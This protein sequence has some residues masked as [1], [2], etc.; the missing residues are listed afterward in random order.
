MRVLSGI[1]LIIGFM[2]LG[3]SEEFFSDDPIYGVA[4]LVIS[5]LFIFI[6]YLF[7]KKSLNNEHE[8]YIKENPNVGF[9]RIN[10]FVTSNAKKIGVKM[11]EG[12]KVYEIVHKSSYF[13]KEGNYTIEITNGNKESINNIVHFTVES[14]NVYEVKYDSVSKSYYVEIGLPKELKS[15]VKIREKVINRMK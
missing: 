13:I 3:V 8:I 4:F 5:F 10:H 12:Q 1:F 9:L 14:G 15:V 7:F 11:L 6:G 2:F